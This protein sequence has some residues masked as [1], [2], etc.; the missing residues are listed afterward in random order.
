M[1]KRICAAL[2]ALLMAASLAAAE[3]V[4]T[5]T[6]DPAAV[7][8]TVP[9]QA[10]LPVPTHDPNEGWPRRIVITV[11][12]DCTLGATENLKS[13]PRSFPSVIQEK[14]LAHPFSGLYD[15]FAR[16][17]LTIVNFEGTLTESTDKAQKLHNFKGPAE[18]A[19]MLTF[20]SV[21]AVILANNHYGD[22][23]DEGKADTK[24][25]LDGQGILYCE[26]GTPVVYTVRGVKIGLI[27]NTFPYKDGKR[28][29]SK[30]VKA[31]RDAGCQ[32]VLASFHWGEEYVA[33]FSA[34]QRNIGRAAIKAGVDAVFGHHPHVL[35]GIERYEDTYILYS[36]G[37]L[38]FGGHVNPEDRDTF[39]AQFTFTVDEDGSADGPELTILPMR[40]TEIPDKKGTDYRPVFAQGDEIERILKRI[41]NRSSKMEDF[42][43]P[44]K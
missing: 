22:Y 13:D 19:Q 6:D 39:I 28:D 32:I 5:D 7:D 9:A 25:A 44:V 23:G 33:D 4:F 29:I 30:D 27:A 21:E 37:N 3:I 11:G 36:L 18:Y 35:Q 42:S 38:V 24:Q 12:G 2:L 34:D 8:G 15:V 14:G 41:L 26:Q 16:D 20:G 43:N 31:L 10:P 1:L 40:L 17:D